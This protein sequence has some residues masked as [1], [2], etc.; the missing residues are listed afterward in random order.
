M[1]LLALL[2]KF[3]LDD[4]TK[5]YGK[6]SLVLIL[7]QI[8]SIGV[9]F[10]LVPLTLNQLGVSEYGIWLTLVGIIEWFNFFDIGLGHGLRNKYAEAKAKNQNNELKRYVSTTFFSMLIISVLI[11]LIFTFVTSFLDWSSILNSPK[12]LNESLGILSIILIGM[13]CIRFVINII[14]VLL[15]ADQNPSAPSLILTSGSV[16]SLIAVLI[17]M[18]FERITLVSLGIALSFSQLLPLLFAFI[19]L[20]KTKYKYLSP[21]IK[22]FSR[23]HLNEI[24][25][26][27]GKFFLIQLTTLVLFQSNNIIIAKVCGLSEVTNYNIGFKYLNILS[28]FFMTFL[29]P[30]WSATTDAYFRK[31]YDWITNMFSKLNKMWLGLVFLGLIM[32]FL[33]PF[34]YRLWLNDTITPDFLLLS[35]LLLNILFLMRSTLFRSFMNG[36]GKIKLQFLVTFVQS[37]LHIPFAIFL[38]RIYGIYGIVFVMFFWNLTNS[39]WEHYQYNRILN[40]KAKGIWNK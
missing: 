11:F 28:L 13:F 9:S 16:I 37:L 10:V 27:G 15:T 14:S 23:G 1:S 36:V 2:N 30:L 4:R 25:S 38:G 6:N 33:S 18:Y 35:I 29:T 5:K 34:A 39:I 20:F 19:Y 7:C 31:D 17:L 32:L 12:S 26:F 40:N 24:F 22:Y 8:V 21:K 3:K